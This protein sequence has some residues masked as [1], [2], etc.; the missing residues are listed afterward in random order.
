MSFSVIVK[1]ALK[2]ISVYKSSILYMLRIYKKRRCKTCA[3][4]K[5]ELVVKFV[6]SKLSNCKRTKKNNETKHRKQ[7]F[8]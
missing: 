7:H 4:E 5:L 6:D 1:D 2:S 3:V 8:V